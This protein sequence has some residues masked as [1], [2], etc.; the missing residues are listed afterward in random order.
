[1]IQGGNQGGA[2]GRDWTKTRLVVF[3]QEDT[4]RFLVRTTFRQLH[5]AE[6]L[7]TSVAADAQ[8]L[9]AMK[10]DMVLVDLDIDSEEAFAF[11]NRVRSAD[12]SPCPEVPVAVVANDRAHAHLDRARLLGIEGVVNKPI[13]AQELAQ[14]VA[15]IIRHP[16]RMPSGARPERPHIVLEKAAPPAR[17][18]APS[19]APSGGDVSVASPEAVKAELARLTARLGT[20]LG[21][22]SGASG[23]GSGGG[24]TGGGRSGGSAAPI[25]LARP[26]GGGGG[27][28][29]GIET[30]PPRPTAGGGFGADDVAAAKKPKASTG[31]GDD[32]LAPPVAAKGP[33]SLGDDDLAAALKPEVKPVKAKPAEPDAAAETAA[34]AKKA[35]KAKA[36]WQAELTE[37]GH[38]PRAG[39]D[40]PAVDVTAAIVADHG[41]WLASQGAEGSRANFDGKDLAGADLTGTVLAGAGFRRA[42]LSDAALA[43]ARLDGADLRFASLSAADCAGAA[44]GV[45][46]LRHANLQLANLEG[47]NL[48]G[49]DLSGAKLRGAR[50]A[51]ADFSG[52]ILVETDLRETDLSQVENLKQ[53][54]VDKALADRTTKLPGGVWLKGGDADA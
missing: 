39:A 33:A 35:K 13:S 21:A 12:S 42:D 1:M 20:S 18:T 8:P 54:Q 49:A 48:R 51:G 50:L 52:A 17:P 38:A 5:I 23:G 19:P 32:D 15:A 2:A 44:L 9:L 7:S 43:E 40:V 29:G 41:K 11:L 10:P 26:G 22:P 27:G 46:Q 37:A 47:A 6:L 25:G 28:G 4:F 30:A 14:R 53:A 34:K 24:L 45:A 3:S 16:M 36:E 31:L